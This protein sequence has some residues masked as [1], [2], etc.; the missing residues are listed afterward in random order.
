VPILR[1]PGSR[2]CYRRRLAPEAPAGDDRAAIDAW[3]GTVLRERGRLAWHDAG[4]A[5]FVPL[6]GEVL[7]NPQAVR[8]VRRHLAAEAGIDM[9][10]VFEV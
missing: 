4:I 6:P 3:F 2:P 8:L 7:A 9:S 5:L 1:L 10:L